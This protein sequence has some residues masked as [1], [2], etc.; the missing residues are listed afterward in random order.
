MT[1]YY[2]CK[3]EE[4]HDLVW[5]TWRKEWVIPKSALEHHLLG[6]DKEKTAIECANKFDLSDFSIKQS[7]T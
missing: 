5:S 7:I 2:I 4:A 6:F 3:T 1:K